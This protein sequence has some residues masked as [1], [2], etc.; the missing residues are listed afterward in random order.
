MLLAYGCDGTPNTT[1]IDLVVGQTSAADDNSAKVLHGI[2]RICVGDDVNYSQ[3]VWGV[4]ED[5]DAICGGVANAEQGQSDVHVRVYTGDELAGETV[6]SLAK[7]EQMANKDRGGIQHGYY[8]TAIY[9][10]DDKTFSGPYTDFYEGYDLY[11]ILKRA[12]IPYEPEANVQFYQS[13]MNG[14]ENSWKTV[15]VSLGYLAGNGDAGE[16]DYSSNYMSYAGDGYV[17]SGTLTGLHPIIAYGKNSYPLVWSSGTS[18]VN[19]FAYNYRGPLVAILP[20]NDIEGGSYVGE[21]TVASC[22]LGL[23]EVHLSAD[24]DYT[25]VESLVDIEDEQAAEAALALINALPAKIASD[26]DA[27]AVDAAEA[28]YNALTPEARRLVDAHEDAVEKLNAAVAAAKEYRASKQ[29]ANKSDK[30]A[31]DSD[32]AATSDAPKVGQIVQV[33]SGANAAAYEVTKAAGKNTNGEVFYKKS[34]APKKAK[35]ITVPATIKIAGSTYKVVG[36][37]SGAFSKCKKLTKVTLGKNVRTL[38]SKAFKGTKKLKTL[39]VKT[40]LL[41]KKSVKGC[42]KGSKVKTVK[43]KV[44]TKK[45][46][47]KFVKKY[48][49]VFTKKVAGKKAI[50]K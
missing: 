48:K 10:D 42:L 34:N 39:I 36:V 4:Y 32:A 27:A 23:I 17:S 50:V 3:H 44:G 33:G 41:T 40:K 1:G 35:K 46:N 28:A 15:N 43:V 2:T 5:M 45:L 16:G 13:G 7:I 38:K 22:F 20:Q 21:H 37:S 11:K 19:T 12:G 9:E 49:K 14:L 26:A 47:K 24:A 29:D 8:S 18:G 25:P 30:S 6:V 31:A